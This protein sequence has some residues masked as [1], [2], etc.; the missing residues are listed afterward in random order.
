MQ[1]VEANSP[2]TMAE[3]DKPIAFSII[4]VKRFGILLLIIGTYLIYNIHLLKDSCLQLLK[5]I[6]LPYLNVNEISIQE[7]QPIF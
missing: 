4:F 7:L 2:Q 5:P 6:L 3:E 1:E